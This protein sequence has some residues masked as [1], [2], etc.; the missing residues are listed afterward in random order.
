MLIVCKLDFIVLFPKRIEIVQCKPIHWLKALIF[1]VG[2]GFPSSPLG[3]RGFSVFKAMPKRI[4]GL[5]ILTQ[6]AG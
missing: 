6:D 3:G 1:V 5:E 4:H 2:G